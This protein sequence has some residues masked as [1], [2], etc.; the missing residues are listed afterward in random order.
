MGVARGAPLHK[1]FFKKKLS[2]LE[3]TNLAMIE[4]NYE[5]IESNEVLIKRFEQNCSSRLNFM[6]NGFKSKSFQNY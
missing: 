3:I 4:A 5:F 1:L 6:L 2:D